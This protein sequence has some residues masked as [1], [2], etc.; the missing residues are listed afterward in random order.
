MLADQMRCRQHDGH[1]GREYRK[2]MHAGEVSQWD[3]AHVFHCTRLYHDSPP[4]ATQILTFQ[5]PRVETRE[6]CDN[7]RR[8]RGKN[9]WLNDIQSRFATE[10]GSRPMM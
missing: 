10:L 3:P 2:T 4:Y 9:H 5:Q 7:L 8:L 6:S 1:I